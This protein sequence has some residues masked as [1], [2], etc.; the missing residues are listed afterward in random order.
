MAIVTVGI[1]LAMNVFAVFGHTVRLMAPKFVTPYRMCGKNGKNDAADAAAGGSMRANAGRGVRRANCGSLKPFRSLGYIT[2][3]FRP[4]L[5]GRPYQARAPCGAARERAAAPSLPAQA[6][7]ARTPVASRNGLHGDGVGARSAL[8]YLTC[9]SCPSAAES[10][11][12]ADRPS[13]SPR[14]IGPGAKRPARGMTPEVCEGPL[15]STCDQGGKP[16]FTASLGLLLRDA[17]HGM[18]AM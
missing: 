18:L 7:T 16:S 2:L 13:R 3:A 11:R 14:R 15:D 8:Q 9:R 17:Q 10:Q 4:Q 1:G 12:A 6:W 5:R